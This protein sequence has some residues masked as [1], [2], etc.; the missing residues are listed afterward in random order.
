MLAEIVNN[1]IPTIN[2]SVTELNATDIIPAINPHN[3]NLIIIC[4]VL[5][6]VCLLFSHVYF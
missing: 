5:L 2:P 3:N 4:P 6:S 1:I